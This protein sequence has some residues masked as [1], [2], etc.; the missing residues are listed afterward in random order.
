MSIKRILKEAN[1]NSLGDSAERYA[2]RYLCSQGLSLVARNF[3][4]KGGEIDLILTDHGYLVFVEVR[5]RADQRRGNAAESITSGKQRRI[6]HAAS[7]WLQQHHQFD[8]P[9]RFDAVLFDRQIDDKHLTWL[10]AVF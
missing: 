7:Y 5:Y 2:E 1:S 10:R 8:S 4:C 9:I 6:R 3:R